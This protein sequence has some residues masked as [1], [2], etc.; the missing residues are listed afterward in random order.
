MDTIH[1]STIEVRIIVDGRALPVYQKD[2][3]FFIAGEAG[4]PYSIFVRNVRGERI[5]IL[6]SVDGRNVLQ[7]EAASLSN[8]GMIVAP[9]R[10][11]D[12]HGWR[13]N[14]RETRDFVFSDPSAAIAAQATGS[15]QGVGVI[16]V[17]VFTEKRYQPLTRYDMP[18]LDSADWSV[19]SLASSSSRYAESQ[20]LVSADLG[21]GMGA[22]REDVIG[23]TTFGRVS[24][25]PAYMIEI[26]YRSHAWL[27]E[28][29]I[30]NTSSY[31]S[32]F[33]TAFP[34]DDTGYGKYSK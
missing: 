1:S 10:P 28:Q 6:E 20:S 22:S 33:P 16:G 34:G 30:I 13:I 15:T 11:W 29:G 17:A 23:H 24:S 27:V 32:A 8:H 4:K 12:N 2:G 21:T 9:Y 18:T 26:Q 31:P 19:K 25:I 14:D 5:E 7:D 3:R